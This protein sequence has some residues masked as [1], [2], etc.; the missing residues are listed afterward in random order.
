MMVLEMELQHAES[1]HT[2]VLSQVP[3]FMPQF[4]DEQ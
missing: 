4:Q 2:L 1:F 3:E